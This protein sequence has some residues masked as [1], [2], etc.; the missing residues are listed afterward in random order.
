MNAQVEAALIEKLR[1]LPPERRAEVADFVEFLAAKERGEA[2][3]EFL[4]V[5]DQVARAQMPALSVEDIER[6]IRALRLE[7][8]RRTGP[9][10]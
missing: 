8:G 5:A 6:E 10:R 7:R 4:A 9:A 3:T 2:L 1:A